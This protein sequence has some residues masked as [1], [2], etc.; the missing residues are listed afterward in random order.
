VV[1]RRILSRLRS[2]IAGSERLAAVAVPLEDPRFVKPGEPL[3]QAFLLSVDDAGAYLVSLREELS[4][5]HLRG[6]SDLPF[7]ADVAPK[8]AVLRRAS[9]FAAGPTWSIEP[10]AGEC[11]R[12]GGQRA[13]ERRD[14]APGD[15]VE[16]AR[17][18]AFR[19]ELP[20]P[21][22]ETA[23][24]ELLAGAECLGAA[25]VILFAEGNGG[26][27]GIGAGRERHVRVPREGLE[28]ELVRRAGRLYLTSEARLHGAE[29][30]EGGLSLPCPPPRR[31]VVSVAS[32]AAHPAPF[33]LA[34]EP[35]EVR[36]GPDPGRSLGGLPGGR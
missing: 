11:V 20:D 16:L 29:P 4:L 34:I 19:F 22:S 18:L 23:L 26:R 2:A 9:G 1:L 5:G 33:S 12:V 27:L 30:G 7:L 8:H 3:E 36:R 6:A 21:A 13:T 17:N 31:F 28:L 24:L 32:E 35:A 15:E 10:I 14:L 25:H